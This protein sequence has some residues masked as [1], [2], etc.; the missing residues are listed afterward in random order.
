VSSCPVGQNSHRDQH[1][2]AH[3]GGLGDPAVD[4]VLAEDDE[5]GDR[6]VFDARDDSGKPSGGHAKKLCAGGIRVAVVRDQKSIPLLRAGEDVE[7]LD[8]EGF[9]EACHEEELLVCHAG[10]GNDGRLFCWTALELGRCHFERT[11]PFCRDLLAAD[12]R[13]F[14]AVVAVE[15]VKIEP[16]AVRHP[17]RID[18]VIFARGDPVDDVLAARDEDVRAGAACDIDA[19]GFLEEPDAH[20][21]AEILAREGADRADV[22][23]VERVVAVEALARIDRE[24][25]VAAAVQEAE[26]VIVRDLLHEPDAARAHDAALVIEDDP[27]AKVDA[28]GLFDFVL[29]KPRFPLAKLNGKFLEP[30]LAGLVA[31][32]A[33]ERVVDEEEFHH[34]IPALLDHRGRRLDAHAVRDFRGAGDRRAR[35]P[36][37]LRASVRAEHRLPVGRHFW[38]AHLDETHAAVARRAELRMVAIVRD[39]LPAFHAGL[40]QAGA[41]GELLPFPVHLHVDHCDF[42]RRSAHFEKCSW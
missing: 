28:L 25:R 23:G 22:D 34:A 30:A 36:R 42:R 41:F 15:V 38:H 1:I 10:G 26:H 29:D 32:R 3:E 8:P 5:S 27:L 33:V 20:L 4:R 17:A 21:E 24:R 39:E 16:V 7:V 6:S 9:C 12:E 40:N 19:L 31:D 35:A 18:E 2:E 14:E 13:F 37:D 11:R